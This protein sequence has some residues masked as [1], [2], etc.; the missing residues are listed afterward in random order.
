VWPWVKLKEA[1]GGCAACNSRPPNDH[2]R[3]SGCSRGQR[4]LLYSGA[5][6]LTGNCLRFPL[7]LKQLSGFVL[8]SR[9]N[10]FGSSVTSKTIGQKHASRRILCRLVQFKVWRRTKSCQSSRGR[11]DLPWHT[12]EAKRHPTC[13]LARIWHPGFLSLPSFDLPFPLVRFLFRRGKS[14]TFFTEFKQDPASGGVGAC[15]EVVPR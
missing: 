13:F 7:L 6:T 8:P 10:C 11:W 4:Q 1:R 12:A 14:R 9:T 5:S 15:W 3:P 2:R